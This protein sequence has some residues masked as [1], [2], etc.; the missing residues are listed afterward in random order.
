MDNTTRKLLIDESLTII[1]QQFNNGF[2]RPVQQGPMLMAGCQACGAIQGNAHE[3][4]CQV[5]RLIKNLV[6]LHN[7]E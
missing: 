4:D 3:Q 1:E 6:L 2:T 7:S 5:G